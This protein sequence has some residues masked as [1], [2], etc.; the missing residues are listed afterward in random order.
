MN[1]KLILASNSPRRQQLLKEL[2]LDFQVRT[3]EVDE[4]YPDDLAADKVAEYLAIKKGKAYQMVMKQDELIIT[5]DTTVVIGP[6][7]LNKP[8]DAE[9]A[10]KMLRQLSGTIHQVITG[11]CITLPDQ[12][13]SFRELTKVTF[14]ELEDKEIKHYVNHYHPFDKAGAYAIQEWIGMV[15]IEHIDGSYFNV[16]GL[17]VEKL[18]SRLKE[19]NKAM[20]SH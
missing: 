5:A 20:G 16:V 10:Y 14:R 6:T 4:Q 13:Q 18:Y 19:I 11:V 8:A 17:P 9:E 3:I 12:Q 15:G 2:E 7:V 1:F